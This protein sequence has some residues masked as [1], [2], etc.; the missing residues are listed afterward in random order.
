MQYLFYGFDY[1][2]FQHQWYRMNVCFIKMTIKENSSFMT[3][4]MHNKYMKMKKFI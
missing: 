3:I 2:M 4:Q 1:S